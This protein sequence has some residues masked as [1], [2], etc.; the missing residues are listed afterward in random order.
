MHAVES[1]AAAARLSSRNRPR[2]CTQTD[3]DGPIAAPATSRLTPTAMIA[4]TTSRDASPLTIHQRPQGPRAGALRRP[5]APL[6]PRRRG[7]QLRPGPA[8]ARGAGRRGGAR[9]GERI[10]DVAT[11]TGMVAAA[12]VRRYGAAVVGLDQS[13]QMLAAAARADRARR[14]SSRARSRSSRAR[15]SGCRSRDGEFDHLT[16]T[17]LLRYVDDPAATLR[18][19]ARVVAPGGRIASLEFG[20]PAR[21]PWRALWRAYARSGCRCSAAPISARV[22]GGR[23]LPRAQHPRL[24]RAPS[25]RDACPACGGRRASSEVAVRPMSFGA[26][27]VMWGRREGAGGHAG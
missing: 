18:E 4:R 7:A 26:G 12:L 20:V 2:H 6:R 15:P 25:A 11:G 24:L 1:M 13:P 10:L 22:G 3:F 21:E 23:A 27:V 19:L 9:P 14:P 16:F 17:Y 5:A 8:L